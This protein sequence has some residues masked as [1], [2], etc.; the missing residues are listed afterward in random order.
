LQA[1]AGVSLLFAPGGRPSAS[2]VERL[3][4]DA[5][6]SEIAARIS[7]RPPDDH[8]WL[9]LLVSGLTFDL[10]GLAPGMAAPILPPGPVYGLPADVDKFAFE[11]VLLV[12]GAH[13]AAG[14]AMMPVVRVLIGLAANLALQLPLTAICWNPA[15]SWMEPRYFGRMAV[16]WLSRGA[17]PVL[18]LTGVQ[19]RSDGA[20]ESTG[21]AYFTGQEVRLNGRGGEPDSE[22]V[23]LAGRIVDHLV[24]HGPLESPDTLVAPGGEVL[25]LEPSRDGRMVEVSRGA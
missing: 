13:I 6:A 9:E 18:G 21:L 25:L 7:H 11:A 8:G 2:D 14:G 17:F 20:F 23:K 10:R 3:M 24:R 4:L 12:P 16:S 15:Q 19:R 22:A 5:A 1:K